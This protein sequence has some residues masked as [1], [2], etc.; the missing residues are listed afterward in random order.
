MTRRAVLLLALLLGLHLTFSAPKAVRSSQFRC[1]EVGVTRSGP[2][3]ALMSLIGGPLPAVGMKSEVAIALLG[4][5][6]WRQPRAQPP[7]R[8]PKC[9]R[10]SKMLGVG[11]AGT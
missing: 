5:S 4:A 3:K 8:P 9:L 2:R 1:F 6:S 7:C 11:T 10:P